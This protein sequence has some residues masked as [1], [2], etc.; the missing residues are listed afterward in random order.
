MSNGLPE[1][2]LLLKPRQAANALGISERTLWTYTRADKIP[3]MKIGR[4]VRYPITELQ[5]WIESELQVGLK[6]DL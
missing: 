1:A 6:G 3:S 4:L 2:Q 5:R